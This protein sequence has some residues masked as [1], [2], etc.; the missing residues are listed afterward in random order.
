[1]RVYLNQPYFSLILK[2]L[3]WLSLLD[4][5]W[6]QPYGLILTHIVIHSDLLPILCLLHSLGPCF[7]MASNL[8]IAGSTHLLNEHIMGQALHQ[9]AKH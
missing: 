5:T 2:P 7:F 9:E 3:C 4:I 1:M 6:D 8:G